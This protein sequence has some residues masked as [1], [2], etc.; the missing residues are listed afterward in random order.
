MGI[1]QN[2]PYSEKQIERIIDTPDFDSGKKYL[3]RINRKTYLL[4]IFNLCSYLNFTP[5]ILKK[6]SKK[7]QCNWD[8]QTVFEYCM[9]ERHLS[10]NNYFAHYNEKEHWLLVSHKLNCF[11]IEKFVNNL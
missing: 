1:P 5:V 3:I 8:N 7:L 11:D 2:P 9:L 10:S 6:I 4:D